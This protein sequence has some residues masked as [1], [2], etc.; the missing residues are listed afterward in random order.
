[1]AKEPDPTRSIAVV[2]PLTPAEARHALR[3]G[4]AADASWV[5]ALMPGESTVVTGWVQ[6]PAFELIGVGPKRRFG[7]IR[8][9]PVVTRRLRGTIT[10][11]AGG[12]SDVS[13][14]YVRGS[15]SGMIRTSRQR[16]QEADL[17]A[18]VEAQVA[19]DRASAGT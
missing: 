5:P 14:R 13:A 8:R 4:L 10:A 2:S 15:T 19:G 16:R 7:P 17:L 18:W 6:D 11:H 9:H 1:M 3:S 12:G